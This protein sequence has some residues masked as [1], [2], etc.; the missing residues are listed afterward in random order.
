MSLAE[1][2]QNKQNDNCSKQQNHANRLQSLV[3]FKP[4]C[5]IKKIYS[6]YFKNIFKTNFSFATTQI[7]HIAMTSNLVCSFR[8][9]CMTF[10]DAACQLPVLLT[11]CGDMFNGHISFIFSCDIFRMIDLCYQ[12]TFRL[13]EIT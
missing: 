5:K 11:L 1:Y 2:N 6:N 7:P 9:V 8:I 4:S 13:H 3:S 12:F 10:T